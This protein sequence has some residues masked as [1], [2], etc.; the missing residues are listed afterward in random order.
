MGLF[1]WTMVGI[2]A[3]VFAVVA[4]IFVWLL[5]TLIWIRAALRPWPLPGLA[6]MGFLYWTLV[7]FN[8]VALAAGAAIFAWL[9]YFD[10]M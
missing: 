4:G 5:Y 2:G 7:G 3:V 6:P 10:P 1:Y 9:L 8:A